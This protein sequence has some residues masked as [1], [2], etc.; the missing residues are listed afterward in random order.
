MPSGSGSLH[1]AAG[2]RRS[3]LPALPSVHQIILPTPW[4]VGPVQV[5]L[6]E[7]DPLTLI[8]TGVRSPASRSALEAGLAALGHRVA[9]VQ[10]IVLTHYHGDHLGQTQTL[11]AAGRGVEVFAHRAERTMIEHF[12]AER[13]ENIDATNALFAEFGV[14]D[15]LIAKQAAVRYRALHDDP[16]CEATPVEHA[17]EDGDGIDAGRLR[18]EVIHAPGHTAGHLLLYEPESGALVTG[19]HLM[20]G[21]V[22]FTDTYLVD[23]RPDPADPLRRRPRFRGLPAYLASLRR[24]RRRTFSAILPAHGGVVDRPARAIEEA[25]LFYDVRVQRV[26]RALARLSESVERGV[27]AWE[28]WQ[29]LFPKIDPVLQMRTR[30]LMVI[31]ALDVL[32]EAGRIQVMRD[33]SGV[34]VHHRL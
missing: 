24:L 11:R 10:R 6:V 1:P 12:S 18:F 14:P 13:D 22:P 31:G 23:E 5:Y 7:G 21:A 30:M 15:D 17:V 29:Q 3:P 25:L 4:E 34:L 16:L 9:D 33:T 26:E 27:T 32:G 28:L 2:V 8:D 19:D 20:G